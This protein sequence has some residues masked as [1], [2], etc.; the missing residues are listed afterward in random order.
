MKHVT[1]SVRPLQIWECAS[2]DLRGSQQSRLA[3]R[4]VVGTV[5]SRLFRFV[6]SLPVA[7]S[8]PPFHWDKSLLRWSY[9]LTCLVCESPFVR[10]FLGALPLF[11]R[12]CSS[13]ILQ[14]SIHLILPASLPPS[15]SLSLSLPLSFSFS[16]SLLHLS[17]LLSLPIFLS[18]LVPL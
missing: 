17:M 2:P 12:S 9:T 18:L 4:I 7:V 14:H 8:S 5:N 15:F 11:L 1:G 13:P 6:S 10:P 3:C 16:S